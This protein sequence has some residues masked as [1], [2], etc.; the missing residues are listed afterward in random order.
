MRTARLAENESRRLAR[1]R[2]RLA[3]GTVQ[4]SPAQPSPEA[5]QGS[6]ATT[7]MDRFDEGGIDAIPQGTAP[8]GPVAT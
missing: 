7:G 5:W 2:F 3:G 6:A 4:R 8:A 1:W